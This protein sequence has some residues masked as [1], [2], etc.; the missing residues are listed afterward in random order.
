MKV[1]FN[2]IALVKVRFNIIASS[3]G[4]PLGVSLKRALGTPPAYSCDKANIDMVHNR[5]AGY[6]GGNKFLR[7]SE[8]PEWKDGNSFQHTPA[9]RCSIWKILSS[10]G[11]ATV[12]AG[13]PLKRRAT[14]FFSQL[15]SIQYGVSDVRIS[16]LVARSTGDSEI[17]CFNMQMNVWI[18]PSSSYTKRSILI[19]AWE[20]ERHSDELYTWMGAWGFPPYT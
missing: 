8:Y 15:T 16:P 6:C 17:Q 12:I 5:R 13:P 4:N 18:N 10:C 11:P 1:R 20:S 2:I 9:S 7:G 3:I 19:T 14:L